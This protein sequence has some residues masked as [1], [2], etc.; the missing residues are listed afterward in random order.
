MEEEDTTLDGFIEY[1]D[2]IERK[3]DSEDEL[4]QYYEKEWE[5]RL[6]G[7]LVR[8]PF[9][10]VSFDAIYAALNKIKSEE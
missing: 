1:M 7:K 8:I 5:V 9:D 6:G 2:A 3:S 4:L 10:A